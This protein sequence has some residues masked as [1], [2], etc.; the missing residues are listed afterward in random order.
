MW[1]IDEENQ[2]IVL[3]SE[4]RLEELAVFLYSLPS[5]HNYLILI[6]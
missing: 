2:T 4:I 3:S 5:D 1:D 6:Q